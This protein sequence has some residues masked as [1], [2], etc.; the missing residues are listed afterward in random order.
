MANKKGL[1]SFWKIGTNYYVRTIRHNYTGRLGE[2]DDH[3]IVLVDATWLPD[4]W[5]LFEMT[6]KGTIREAEPLPDGQQ[7][8]INR[9]AI[10]DATEW[11]FDLPRTK[12]PAINV[13]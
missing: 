9:G 13:L 5:S 4:D 11:K 8:V 10:I 12:L 7:L 6:S 2:I 1:T 3:E